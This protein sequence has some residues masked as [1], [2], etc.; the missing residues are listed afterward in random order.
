MDVRELFLATARVAR[1]AIGD[2]AVGQAWDDASVLEDQTIGGLAGHIARGGVWVVEDYL[3][4]EVPDAPRA[5]SA[6]VYFAQ[7]AAFLNAEDHRLIR[8]RGA[9]VAAVGHRELFATLTRRLDDLTPRL[10]AEPV[11]RIVGAAG[12]VVVMTL[13][14]YLETR[15]VE[16]VV[17]LDDLARS[18]GRD[19]WRVPADAQNLALHVG[20]DVAQLRYDPTDVLRALYRSR[21]DPVFPVI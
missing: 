8:E 2:D 15:I 4:A 17:H 18:L 14:S 19:P 1:D 7:S 21:L 20:I 3:N 6:A 12:G 5:K 11:D 16:Q 9:Q 10:L 13:D